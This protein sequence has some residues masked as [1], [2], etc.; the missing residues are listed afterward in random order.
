MQIDPGTHVF[1]LSVEGR[2]E[3]VLNETF[4]A[5]A[6]VSL[7]L[8]APAVLQNG[9]ARDAADKPSRVPALV[10]VG[11]G[12]AGVA[13]GSVSG[14]IAFRKKSA[15]RDACA[16]SDETRCSSERASGNRIADVSTAGFFLGGAAI[17]VGSALYLLASGTAPSKATASG[18]PVAA[19]MSPI[20]PAVGWGMVGIEGGF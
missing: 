6:R 17:A 20:R 14:L 4:A 3:V 12:V 8:D 9:S 11:L 13:V 16:G 1:V 10:V 15:V 7:D 5:G 19:S 18:T 2:L